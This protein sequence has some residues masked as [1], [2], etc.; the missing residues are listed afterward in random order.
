MVAWQ[1]SLLF[2][3]FFIEI[4]QTNGT[5]LSLPSILLA[6]DLDP[7]CYINHL[8]EPFMCM[9]VLGPDDDKTVV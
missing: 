5:V 2:L 3:I 7:V 8:P 6:F 1:F 9:L 4:R